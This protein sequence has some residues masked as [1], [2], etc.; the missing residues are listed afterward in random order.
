MQQTTIFQSLYPTFKFNKKYINLF[1]SFAGIGSQAMALKTLSN[2]FGFT[3]NVTGISE[4]DKYAIASYEA[5]HGKVKN[6]GDISKIEQLPSNID[7]FT[8]SFPCQDISNAGQGKGFSK[9]SN[10]RSGLLWQVE[11]LLNVSDKPKVLLM[12]NVKQLVSE[13]FKTDLKAWLQTL[14]SLG[15]TT[16]LGVL[17]AKDYG[18]PQNRERVF[19]VSILGQFNYNYPPTIPLKY[20]LIDFLELNKNH[21]KLNKIS[22]NKLVINKFDGGLKV[23]NGTKKGYIM[24]YPYDGIYINHLTGGGVL[25]KGGR[26]RVQKHIVP[27]IMTSPNTAFIDENL[28]IN[29]LTVRESYRLMGVKDKDIDMIDQSGNSNSQLYKQAGNSIVVDVLY[30]IF[31]QLFV[32]EV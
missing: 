32:K 26:G 8:Y 7:I 22:Y 4:I 14:E 13:N 12:E 3:L 1:E 11:R 28:E 30:Y 16:Y 10:T 5:I 6:F 21:A 19:A 18:I 9:G 27:T 23:L 24:A 17:N 25:N 15:Y 29:I 20:R 2:E 31:K